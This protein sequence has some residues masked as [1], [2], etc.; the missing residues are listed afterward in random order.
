V[1]SERE[2]ILAE[3]QY[4]YSTE[5]TRNPFRYLLA[6][7]RALR[8]PT[9]TYEVA[10]VEMGFARSRLGRRFAR[11][12]DVVDTLRRDARTQPALLARRPCD[13]IDLGAL[14]RMRE[15]TLGRVF[16]EHCRARGINPNLGY[17]PP[18]SD[19]DWMLHHIALT[20]DVWHVVTGWG[21]DLTGET[22]LGGFYMGQLGA[23][24]F[25]GYLIG[26]LSLSTALRR[27]SFQ[28]FMEAVTTG[29]EMGKRAEPLV[30]VDWSTLWDVPLGDVRARFGLSGARVIGEG[31]R[32]AA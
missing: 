17:I 1:E 10:I 5:P 23:P 12:E 8:D 15:G 21:N 7:W 4:A 30:G 32:A 28:E 31:I 20:H 19:V 13:P 22:G 27:R 16:A 2:L 18:E 6:V 3:I 24:A 29:Y 9:D 26:L 25:F 11:W 14:A